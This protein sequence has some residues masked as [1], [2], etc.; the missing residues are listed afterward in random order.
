VECHVVRTVN[1]GSIVES[2]ERKKRQHAEMQRE[3]ALLMADGMREEL[4]FVNQ[5][6]RYVAERSGSVPAWL[7]RKEYVA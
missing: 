6:K 2:I 5:P 3:M 4:G 7:R 1:E